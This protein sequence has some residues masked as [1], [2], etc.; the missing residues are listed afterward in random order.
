MSC[1]GMLAGLV[2]ITAPCAFVAPWA[3]CLIGVIAGFLVCYSVEFFDKVLKIDDPCGAI[4]VHGVCGAWGVIAVGLFA[5][6]T[7]GAGWNGVPGTREG[8]VLRRRR[9]ARRA[10]VRRRRRLHLG[11]GRHVAHLR[12]RQEVEVAACRA[13]GRDRR[14]STCGSSGRWRTPTTCCRP[15]DVGGYDAE[16]QPSEP[17]PGGPREA[18]HRARQAVQARRG[19]GGAH[20]ARPSRHHDHRSRRASAANAATRRCT[21]APSTRWSSCRRCASRCSPTTTTPARVADAIVNAARTGQIGDGKVWISP[22][23]TIIRVR[24]G[25][26]DHDAI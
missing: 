24:T 16:P 13:R 3:A 19:E 4:S 2:A 15:T 17:H 1:N 20:R 8:T 6:G 5:D 10:D 21:A 26:M 22:V 25:E 7:Y 18:R 14:V 23:D 11:V 9:P 12:R